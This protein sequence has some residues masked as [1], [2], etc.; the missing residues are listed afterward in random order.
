[1]IVTLVVPRRHSV[2]AD[3][4]DMPTCLVAES[5]GWSVQIDMDCPHNNRWSYH[6]MAIVGVVKL[7]CVHRQLMRQTGVRKA[8]NGAEIVKQVEISKQSTG[9]RGGCRIDYIVGVRMIQQVDVLVA[10]L[11]LISPLLL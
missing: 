9:R 11:A 5:L 7:D 1:M 3:R 4:F 2:V 10:E 8:E 6:L